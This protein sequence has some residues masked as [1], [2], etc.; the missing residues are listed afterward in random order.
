[1]F[2]PCIFGSILS[3][4]LLFFIVF[5]TKLEAA[6]IGLFFQKTIVWTIFGSYQCCTTSFCTGTVSEYII[7]KFILRAI[8]RDTGKFVIC[9]FIRNT[10]C[11]SLSSNLLRIIQ[12]NPPCA[13]FQFPPQGCTFAFC[14]IYNGKCTN[15]RIF[16]CFCIIRSRSLIL[17]LR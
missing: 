14:L 16:S 12:R 7:F 4:Q 11:L 13:T 5:I 2:I 9:I 6:S 10:C 1:M 8:M 3:N 15:T 17:H